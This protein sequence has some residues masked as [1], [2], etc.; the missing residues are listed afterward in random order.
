MALSGTT[1]AQV[2]R[3]LAVIGRDTEQDFE[4]FGSSEA[5]LRV[6]DDLDA[7]V[8]DWIASR[9]R[10]EVLESFHAARI[11]VA[12]VNDLGALLDDPHLRERASVVA[13]DDPE[14]GPMFFVAPTPRLSATPGRHRHT[15][16]RL[17]EHNA[18]V[19]GEWLGMN[20]ELVAALARDGAI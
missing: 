17:G 20:A 15:G 8:A 4:R 18:E 3:I 14:I 10:E 16:P 2:A 9:S 6:A 1:D 11:P 19:Y 13:L 5:R 12:P 7:V